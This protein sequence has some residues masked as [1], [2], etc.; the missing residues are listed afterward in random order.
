[1][2]L[3]CGEA[4]IDLKVE[5]GTVQVDPARFVAHPG[6]SPANVAVAVARLE[7]EVAL[8]AR[9]SGDGFGRLLRSHL[10][11]NGVDLRYAVDAEEPTS[12][13]V[14]TV[15]GTG[16]PDYSF[17][18][19]ATADWMWQPGELPSSLPESVHAIHA[20]SL[21]LALPPGGDLIEE[22]LGRERERRTITLDPN[23]RPR[24]VGDRDQYRRRLEAWVRIAHLVRVS[25]EDLRWTYP[26]ASPAETARRWASSG[27]RFVVLTLGSQGS[28]GLLGEETLLMPSTPIEVVDTVGAGDSFMAGL[29]DWLER[30]DRLG[31]GLERLSSEEARAALMFAGRVAAITCTREGADPPR[32]AEL[33]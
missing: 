33:G 5:A 25:D 30:H 6:G 3:V 9:L 19:T 1:M 21:A 22:M 11:R 10:E 7:T 13:A 27:P 16:G 32:R 31:P 18:V 20:G 4:L 29:L 8:C 14:V 28:L 15:D 23:V 17:Y 12:L 26:D 24:L 2:I